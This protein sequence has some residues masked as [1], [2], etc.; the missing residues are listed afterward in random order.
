MKSSCFAAALLVILLPAVNT[1]GQAIVVDHS[2]TDASMIPAP[3]MAA[4]RDQVAWVYGHSSHGSQIESGAEYMRDYV[5]PIECNL[6]RNYMTVPDQG[7]PPGLREGY[8]GSWYWGGADDFYDTACSMLD[9]DHSSSPIRVFMWS[10]CGE[11]SSGST[12]V[13]GYLNRMT[14]LES[15]YPGVLFVYMTGHTDEGNDSTV[16]ANN[17]LVRAH[18]AAIGG[19][20]FDFADIERYLPDGS[21]Y[22]GTADDE[23]PWCQ[24]WCDVHPGTCPDPVIS[25][26][27]SHSL[28]CYLKGQAW[29]WLSARIAGWA[30]PNDAIFI[31]GFEDGNLFAWSETVP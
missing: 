23:C 10:W 1:N 21:P 26:A 19:I 16:R 6:I 20:L 13:Q 5:D 3:W 18:V 15:E 25:C 27:H 30:G 11:M 14:Q 29:W 4:A 28:L 22:S 9:E 8:Y 12:D 2:C 31:D 7:N 17:D 24:P